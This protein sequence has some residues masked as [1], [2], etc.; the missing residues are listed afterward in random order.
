MSSLSEKCNCI[1]QLTSL[2]HNVL[3]LSV[4]RVKHDC[5]VTSMVTLWIWAL[6][7]FHYQFLL[8]WLP[9]KVWRYTANLLYQLF[10]DIME[11]E[12]VLLGWKG[13]VVLIYNKHRQCTDQHKLM[14]DR[15]VFNDHLRKDNLWKNSDVKLQLLKGESLSLFKR[16]KQRKMLQWSRRAELKWEKHKW[17]CDF[18]RDLQL[19]APIC[20]G[21]APNKRASLTLK[22]IGHILLMMQCL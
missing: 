18:I 1:L 6:F 15:W 10:N 5:S 7:Q 17:N 4:R 13:S 16:K 8:T 3:C 9:L 12:K 14:G 11:E 22:F 20:H 19:R 21:D 2:T